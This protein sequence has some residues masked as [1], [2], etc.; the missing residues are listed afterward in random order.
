M[1]HPLFA[2]KDGLNAV[3][4]RPRVEFAADD[5]I[6]AIS[7]NGDAVVANE[8]DFLLRTVGLDFSAELFSGRDASITFDIDNDER[9][10]AGLGKLQAF[11][12]GQCGVDLIAMEPE[13]LI[14]QV[15]DGFA[16]TDVQNRRGICTHAGLRLPESNDP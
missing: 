16:G 11:V 4:H 5:L 3:D 12:E 9:I 13:Y 7:L 14:P 1:P 10:F 15:E 8:Y 6:G 2:F